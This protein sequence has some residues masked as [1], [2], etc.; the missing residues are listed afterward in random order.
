MKPVLRKKREKFHITFR[1]EMKQQETKYVFQAFFQLFFLLTQKSKTT[2]P[3]LI[4]HFK[5][6]AYKHTDQNRN[7]SIIN[8]S[9]AL[10]IINLH[11]V[12]DSLVF[13]KL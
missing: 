10:N 9:T 11:Q 4:Q 1:N 3:L 12:Q 8:T 7:Y 13:K 2:F 5:L 6:F